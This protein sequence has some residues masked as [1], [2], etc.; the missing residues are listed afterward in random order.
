MNSPESTNN[1]KT[2]SELAADALEQA[3]AQG[4]EAMRRLASDAVDITQR[5]VE[6]WREQ[7]EVWRDDASE[8]IRANPLRSVLIAA[9][10]GMVITLLLRAL[11]R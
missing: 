3:T 1:S 6:Q 2:A 10:A 4:G 5:S 8:H 7:A 9:G 11:N